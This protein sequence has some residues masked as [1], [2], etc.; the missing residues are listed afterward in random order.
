MFERVRTV[1]Q[2]RTPVAERITTE[3]GLVRLRQGAGRAYDPALVSRF[4]QMLSLQHDRARRELT[5]DSA[6]KL[7][8]G[9][10]LSRPL[11]TRQGVPIAPSNIPITPE[12]IERL[13][14]FEQTHELR[15]IFVW[16]HAPDL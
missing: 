16:S 13:L 1:R 2:R 5:F 14:F 3:E 8:E 10:I 12:L 7:R 11:E 15:E 9:M 4:A 6:H